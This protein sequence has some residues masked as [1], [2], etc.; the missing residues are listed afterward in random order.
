MEQLRIIQ[1]GLFQAI[2]EDI[3]EY[4]PTMNKVSISSSSI[5]PWSGSDEGRYCGE[6]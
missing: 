4:V 1:P 5:N 3:R 2:I 6:D